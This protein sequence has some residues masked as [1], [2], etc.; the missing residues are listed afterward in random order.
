MTKR[1]IAL[2]AGLAA[3]STLAVAPAAEAA[4]Q[5]RQTGTVVGALTGG[6]LGHA[7]AGRGDRTEGALLGAA[8]G[9]LVGNQITKCKRAAPR[10][11]YAPAR[12]YQRA[13]YDAGPRC[14]T[15]SRAFYDH[16]GQVTYQPVQVCRR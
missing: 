7:V 10:R 15:E 11:A 2:L 1:P 5:K 14:R 13:A 12:S 8:A 9:G 6:L 16:T 4:C 3:I